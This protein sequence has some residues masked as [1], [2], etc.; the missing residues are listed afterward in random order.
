MAIQN[1]F[2]TS[3]VLIMES[4]KFQNAVRYDQIILDK[5]ENYDAI[6]VAIYKLNLSDNAK[7]VKMYFYCDYNIKRQLLLIVNTDSCCSNL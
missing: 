1:E 5:T 3:A 2:A 7:S 6:S 4:T